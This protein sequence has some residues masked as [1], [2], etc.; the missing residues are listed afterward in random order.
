MDSTLGELCRHFTAGQQHGE[1]YALATI[2]RTHGSTYRKPG[3]RAL[4]SASGACSGLLSGGC[5]E[6][7]LRECARRVISTGRA[8]RMVFDTRGPEDIVWGY[9]LGCEGVCEIWLEPLTAEGGFAPLPYLRECLEQ[10]R[11]GCFATVV[12]G[13]VQPGELG[14][15]GYQGSASGDALDVLLGG[16]R[17]LEPSV[18]SVPYQQ[19]LLEVF[20]SPVRL[21]TAL[22]LCGAGPDAIPLARL[23][24]SLGWRVT[25]VDHRATFAQSD[26]F[27]AGSRV[28]CAHPS[29]LNAQLQTLRFDAAVIMSHHLPSDI[30]YLR[31]LTARAPR[32]IGLLGPSRRCQRLLDE[33]HADEL[34]LRSRLFGP[35]G[36]DIGA[37]SPASIAVAIIAQIH[38]VIAGRTVGS[39]LH[40]AA[41]DEAPR[42]AR[43]ASEPGARHEA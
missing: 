35:V 6:N 10:E 29:E 36:F 42:G 22:L 38:A 4:I 8:E 21:P 11:G 25:A 31:Q 13:A 23:A 7:E 34:E 2:I 16:L 37:N 17:A 3:V 41:A 5:V 27:P 19:R 39:A 20:I 32:Y 9:A 18:R 40:S 28:I 33:T 43:T 15:H 12:G 14:R 26:R 1:T 30:E 24:D